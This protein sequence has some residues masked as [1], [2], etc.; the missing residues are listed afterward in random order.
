MAVPTEYSALVKR[1]D[2]WPDPDVSGAQLSTA[3]GPA[4][5]GNTHNK[6]VILAK[7][8][9]LAQRAPLAFV[10]LSGVDSLMDLLPAEGHP[11]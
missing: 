1:L 7:S 11:D 4:L 2:Q 5:P 10:I 6:S 9:A 3:V 8:V